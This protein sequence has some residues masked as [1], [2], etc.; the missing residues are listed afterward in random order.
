MG[1][2]HVG[3]WSTPHPAWVLTG[4]FHSLLAGD[5]EALQP[6]PGRDFPLL[7]VPPPH[8]QPHLLHRRAGRFPPSPAGHWAPRWA[9]SE[10]CMH[11]G[12][13][14]RRCRPSAVTAGSVSSGGG[15]PPPPVPP[16]HAADRPLAH[17]SVSASLGSRRECGSGP[18][19]RGRG[20]QALPSPRHSKAPLHSQVSHHPPVSAFHVSNRRDG[21]CISGSI[22]AK[23]RFYGERGLP[24]LCQSLGD[25]GAVLGPRGRWPALSPFPPLRVRNRVGS[26]VPRT[27]SQDS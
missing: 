17:D 20:S 16:G 9:E 24:G 18:T 21:F 8:Q 6:H 5:Q 3:P 27:W 15:E 19:P 25:M 7:L 14:P 22:T 2:P 23:S 1:R 10:P 4:A 11:S 12:G 13:S 26:E